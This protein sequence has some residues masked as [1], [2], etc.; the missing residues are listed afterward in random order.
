MSNPQPSSNETSNV[1]VTG[2]QLDAH[3]VIIRP[4]ITEKSTFLAERYNK[5]TFKVHNQANK[6][7]IKKAIEDL[8]NVKV[9]TVR[10]QNKVGKPKR[11]KMRP[12]H[13]ANWKKAIIT[14]LGDDRIQFI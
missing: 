3:H 12:T 11:Y 7:D 1:Q 14:L 6:L 5:Y 10:T 9:A 2:L 13:T 4:L 8:Y